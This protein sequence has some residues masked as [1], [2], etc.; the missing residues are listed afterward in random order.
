MLLY[1]MQIITVR[2][3][4]KYR[5][6][7]NKSDTFSRNYIDKSF[8]LDFQNI[9][10]IIQ[11]TLYHTK[12][13]MLKFFFVPYVFCVLC[14]VCVQ[15]R[16]IETLRK[17]KTKTHNNNNTVLVYLFIFFTKVFAWN[18]CE[19]CIWILNISQQGKLLKNINC[20]FFCFSIS[21]KTKERQ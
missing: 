12:L 3:H 15:K 6:N 1:I 14:V 13:N 18:L 7:E 8:K 5:K 21:S 19:H 11:Y 20:G 10:R 4:S 9:Y 2:Q 17:C 16:I